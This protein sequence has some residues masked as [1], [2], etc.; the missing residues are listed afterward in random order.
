[1][2]GLVSMQEQGGRGENCL[3]E[4]FWPLEPIY[5]VQHGQEDRMLKAE[6]C[7]IT[8]PRR[9]DTRHMGL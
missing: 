3:H 4:S 8:H 7:A 9:I 2:G 6:I 5:R 1:M